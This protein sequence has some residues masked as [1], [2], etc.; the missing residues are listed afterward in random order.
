MAMTDSGISASDD[1]LVW[2]AVYGSNLLRSRFGCYVQGGK[3]DG[4][5][6]EYAGCRDKTP[7]REARRVMLAHDLYF[8]DHSESWRGAIAFIRRTVSDARTYGRIYLITFG[9]FNDVVRQ[10]NGRSVAGPIVVPSFDT[11][12]DGDYW[13]IDGFR[14]YGGVIKIGT[15]HGQPIL[16]LTAAH[17]NH[18]ASQ[19]D[20]CSGLANALSLGF[21]ASRRKHEPCPKSVPHKC[22]YSIAS[23]FGANPRLPSAALGGRFLVGS[24]A[25]ARSGHSQLDNWGQVGAALR[26]TSVILI[27]GCLPTTRWMFVRGRPQG[28]CGTYIFGELQTV[29]NQRPFDTP[30][31]KIVG[32]KNLQI[33][34][35]I[36]HAE[37]VV[38]P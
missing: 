27:V 17:E 15:R 23:T 9:Q 5:A 18:V 30:K 32:A 8:A 38:S 35:L 24:D 16:S 31:I 2:Y 26:R 11:L 3:P 6:K 10:E 22:C 36:P 34:Q 19:R 4:A 7:P 21:T 33:S 20:K 12:A 13:Q 37:L 25:P 14:L 1:R 28:L 29:K